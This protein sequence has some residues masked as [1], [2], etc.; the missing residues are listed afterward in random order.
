MFARWRRRVLPKEHRPPFAPGE[1]VLAW[2]MLANIEGGWPSSPQAGTAV[3][4]ASGGFP[5][6]G[7]GSSSP[8][9][10]TAVGSGESAAV[11]TNLG[12]WVGGERLP[13]HEISK[14]VWDGSVLTITPSAEVDK[15]AGY[16]VIED[17]APVRLVPADPNHL[18]HQVRLRVTSSVRHSEHHDLSR[19][20]V[21]LAARRVPGV[22]GLSWVARYDAGTDG[23]EPDAI[24]ETDAVFAQFHSK[25]VGGGG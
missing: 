2:A 20:G 6:E 22:D 19:G 15:R 25:N 4:S 23:F 13:W 1:R 12:L 21:W 8:Q 9:G 24:A 14:A 17:L 10:G 16:S 3:G 11:A 7:E 18:P 5:I